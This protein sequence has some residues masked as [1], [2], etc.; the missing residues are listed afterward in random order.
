MAAELFTTPVKPKTMDQMAPQGI[1]SL[2]I[3]ERMMKLADRNKEVV[4]VSVMLV[5]RGSFPRVKNQ[6]A[7]EAKPRESPNKMTFNLSSFE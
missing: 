6:M 4:Y 2:R 3:R 5:P 1:G 7:T